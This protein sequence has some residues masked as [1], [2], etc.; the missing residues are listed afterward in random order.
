MNK[1]ERMR[2][3]RVFSGHFCET[4]DLSG[5]DIE[6][7]Q[8]IMER[9][10]S[11]LF[12]VF[13]HQKDFFDYYPKWSKNVW[14]CQTFTSGEIGF[15]AELECGVRVAYCEPVM[16]ELAIREDSDILLP[17]DVCGEMPFGP[18]V[19]ARAGIH[20]ALSNQH[21]AISVIAENGELL[22]IKPGEFLRLAPPQ[23]LVIGLLN[24]HDYAK[25]GITLEMLAVWIKDLMRDARALGIPIFTKNVKDS[26]WAQMG[27]VPVQEWPK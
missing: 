27:I 7:L 9:H 20:H 26:R 21:G 8:S 12:Q 17:T 3:P 15:P 23:W 13:S 25:F 6:Q 19:I 10:P 16:G 11:H 4:S 22:G 1:I 5:E 24:H 2:K 14:C 18:R